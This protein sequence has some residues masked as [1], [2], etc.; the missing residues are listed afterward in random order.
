MSRWLARV[1]DL[2]F[3]GE[4]V[5]TEVDVGE[6][7]VVVTSHRVLA[8]TPEAEGAN[9][10]YVDRPNVAGVERTTRGTFSYLSHAVKALI[11]GFVLLAA[12]RV[13]SLD[14]MVGG[15]E[16]TTTG[17]MGLGG[18]LSLM[19]SL[20]G[21]L[22]MLDEIMTA[23]GALALLL[24]A[25]L[26]GVYAW[27]REDLLVVEVAGDDDL[28]LPA[29]EDPDD[30]VADRLDRAVRPGVASDADGQWQSDRDPL[31]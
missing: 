13:V 31:G 2:L 15:I 27:T 7:G 26:L 10:D 25:V 9:F 12:G 20:L 30:C 22:A 19:Q 18:F 17:G 14:E 5:E 28:E 21:V 1:D 4:S 3:D 8:F 24:G 16:L 11:V 29:T 6:G 23:T